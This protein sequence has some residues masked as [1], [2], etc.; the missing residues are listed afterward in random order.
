MTDTQWHP[1]PVLGDPSTYPQPNRKIEAVLRN[2]FFPNGEYHFYARRYAF[3][4]L[5]NLSTSGTVNCFE[6]LR[7]RYV[8]ERFDDH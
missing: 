2:N 3:Y 8:E 6:I 1:T 7:W 4:D 5:V